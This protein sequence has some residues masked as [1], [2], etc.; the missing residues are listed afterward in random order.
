MP[1]PLT[2]FVNSNLHRDG[3]VYWAGNITFLLVFIQREVFM[4]KEWAL[5][6]RAFTRDMDQTKFCLFFVFE[7]FTTCE[8]HVTGRLATNQDTVLRFDSK[9]EQGVRCIYIVLGR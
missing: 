6:T 2:N 7:S 8:R 9:S 1:F 3:P 5:V 4:R